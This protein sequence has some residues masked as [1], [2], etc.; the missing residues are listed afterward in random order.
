VNRFDPDSFFNQDLTNQLR[1]MLDEGRP[2]AVC[3][4]WWS[5]QSYVNGLGNNP[6]EGKATHLR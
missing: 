2:P 4:W 6:K 3:R 5:L 1:L